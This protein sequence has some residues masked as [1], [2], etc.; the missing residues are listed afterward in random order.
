MSA[1]AGTK[2]EEKKSFDTKLSAFFV[3][4]RFLFLG[5]IAALFVIA[6]VFGIVFTVKDNSTK[7]GLTEIDTITTELSAARTDLKD[8]ALKAKEDELFERAKVLAEKNTKN[9]TGSRAYMIMAEIQY[10]RKNWNDAKNAWIA[11]AEAN[12]KAYTAA[13][14]YYNVGVCAEEMKDFDEA[15]KYLSLT[16]EAEKFPLKPHALFSIGRIEEQRGNYEQAKKS[17]EELSASYPSDAWTTL[18][19]TRLITLSV[20]GKTN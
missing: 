19:K 14:C 8:D 13:Y 4:T 12:P 6:I 3:K 7:A 18:A 1:N 15:I 11:A 2:N 10:A 9:I 17:Y 5:I 16:T 20:E